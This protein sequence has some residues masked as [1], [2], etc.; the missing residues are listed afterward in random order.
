MDNNI[1]ELLLS[2]AR[3]LENLAEHEQDYSK[4]GYILL[5]AQDIY[6]YLD[7]IERDYMT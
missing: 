5:I 6:T 7:T 4:E 2:I 1:Q 3:N